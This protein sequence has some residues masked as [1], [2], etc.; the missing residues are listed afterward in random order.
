MNFFIDANFESINRYGEE[1]CGDKV[2]LIRNDDSVI[3]VLADGLGSGVKANILSTLTSKI[4]GTMLAKGANID[5][6]VE[7]IA[8]TLPT[9]SE[10]GIAYSTFSI[11]QVLNTG[12]SYLVEFDNPSIIRLRRGIYCELEKRSRTIGS[13]EINES[14][15]QVELND[16]FIMVSDGAVHAGIGQTLNFGWKW[17]NIREYAEKVYRKDMP[18]KSFARQILSV[19]DNLYDHKPGDDTTVVAVKI[20]KSQTVNVMI[21]P[22]SERGLDNFVVS[23]FFESEGMKVACGGTTSQIVSRVLGRKIVTSLNYVNPAVPPTA[24]IEG[25]DLTCEGI[26]T[27][28]K[29]L[30]YV[31]RYINSRD[32][33]CEL[34]DI[35]RQ[36][37]A[38]RLA[39]ILLEEGTGVHFYVGRAINPAHQ[40]PEFPLNLGLKLKLVE[41][42]CECLKALGKQISIEYF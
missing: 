9:C 17:E 26:L 30:D 12:E 35:D 32:T 29:A 22:P 24:E 34:F 13:R 40:N 14:R 25:I 37:G 28:S 36:D 23:K 41:D 5:E 19:C 20:R 6:A 42:M 18:A 4:I 8:G 33:S 21:G 31:K 15:F 38:T 39:R 11:L 3:V 7:T 27:M 16:A 10:R 1:L 2:E